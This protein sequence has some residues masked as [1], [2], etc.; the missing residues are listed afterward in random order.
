[1]ARNIKPIALKRLNAML[2][3]KQPLSVIERLLVALVEFSFLLSPPFA[4][5]KQ[6]QPFKAKREKSQKGKMEAL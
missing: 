3:L 2:L 1:M 5:F 6:M 4:G